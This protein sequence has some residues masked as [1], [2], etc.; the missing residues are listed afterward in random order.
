MPLRHRRSSGPAPALAWVAAFMTSMRLG[1]IWTTRG[2]PEKGAS[3]SSLVDPGKLAQGST[4]SGEASGANGSATPSHAAGGN[5]GHANGNGSRN[6][7]A[8]PTPPTR[9]GSGDTRPPASQN[10]AGS[11]QAAADGGTKKN[12]PKPSEN[13]AKNGNGADL[14]KRISALEESGAA[15]STDGFYG[16]TA[17]STSLT[18]YATSS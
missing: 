15:S 13:E 11:Q 14:D 2:T 16:N 1:W 10:V 5:N 12:E 8:N 7:R 18:W 6:G 17:M 9:N 3:S 4:P